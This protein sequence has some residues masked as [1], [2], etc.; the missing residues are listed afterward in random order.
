[1]TV[2]GPDPR[3]GSSRIGTWIVAI[4]VLLILAIVA[5]MVLTSQAP[6]IAELVVIPVTIL[7]IGLIV[8]DR[9]GARSRS[10]GLVV[11]VIGVLGVV[12]VIGLYLVALGR[13]GI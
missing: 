1:V 6:S 4:G 13:S 5:P 9:P 3:A 7:I 10:L 8:R 11:S 12:A 2:T